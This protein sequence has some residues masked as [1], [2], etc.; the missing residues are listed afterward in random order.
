MKPGAKIF[1]HTAGLKS[2][3]VRKMLVGQSDNI[4]DVGV[5]KINE[6]K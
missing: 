6:G 4:I 2:K 3:K 1:V 5:V